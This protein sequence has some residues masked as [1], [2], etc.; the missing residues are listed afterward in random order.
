MSTG[1]TKASPQINAEHYNKAAEC[2]DKAAEEHRNAAKSCTSGDHKKA[3][4]HGKLGQDHCTKA[5][6][7]SKKAA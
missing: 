6:E 3:A 2:C 4:E 5:Q 1:P 7:H